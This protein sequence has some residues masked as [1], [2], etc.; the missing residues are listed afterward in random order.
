MTKQESTNYQSAAEILFDYGLLQ[1]W[2]CDEACSNRDYE[3]EAIAEIEKLLDQEANKRVEAALQDL[4]SQVTQFKDGSEARSL[5]VKK[6]DAAIEKYKP[7]E[8]EEH[9]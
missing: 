1:H 4:R 2:D 9:E 6:L 5:S 8:V 3:A 7:K